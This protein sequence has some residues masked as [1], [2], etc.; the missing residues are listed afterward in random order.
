M[1]GGWDSDGKGPN[2]WD[3][4][5][6]VY[7]EKIFDRSNGDVA[8][9]S[10]ELYKEDVQLLKEANVCFFSFST[11]FGILKIVFDSDVDGFLSLF[12]FMVS[13]YAQR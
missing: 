5:T 7:S 6:H 2:I 4:L 11:D 1:E 3:E 13:Y 10:Y 8:C 9:N 12:N